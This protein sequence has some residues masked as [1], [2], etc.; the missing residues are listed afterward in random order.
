LPTVLDAVGVAEPSSGHL[1]LFQRGRGCRSAL[2]PVRRAVGDR[3]EHWVEFVDPRG[4]EPSPADDVVLRRRP[5]QG[6]MTSWETKGVLCAVSEVLCEESVSLRSRRVGVIFGA[7]SAVLRSVEN[8]VAL[9]E[10][11][12]S[13]E[14]DV[15]E[16]FRATL[17]SGPVVNVCVYREADIEELARRLDPLETVVR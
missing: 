5:A 1:L 9:I 6:S 10:S 4:T 14:D 11:E 2:D 13:W 16:M 15:G 3:V 8:P 12:E 7:S 17:G